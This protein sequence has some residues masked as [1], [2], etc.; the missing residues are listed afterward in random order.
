MNIENLNKVRNAIAG[1]ENVF[2]MRQDF[3]EIPSSICGY[4]VVLANKDLLFE[5]GLDKTDIPN[6]QLARKYLDLTSIEAYTLF[7]PNFKGANWHYP[8]RHGWDKITREQMLLCVA[9]LVEGI[10]DIEEAW[11]LS[12]DAPY[13]IETSEDDYEWGNNV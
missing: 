7:F 10:E 3:I 9:L 12:S 11:I 13:G 5:S 8:N 2:P 1:E 4:C 6:Y